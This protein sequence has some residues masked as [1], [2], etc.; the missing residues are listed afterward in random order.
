[1]IAC[2][3]INHI[4]SRIGRKPVILGMVAMNFWGYSLLVC[5]QYLSGWLEASVL[6]VSLLLHMFGGMLAMTFIVNV[7]TVDISGAEDR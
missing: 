5:S 4:S 2:G 1:M 6:V 3:V 7:Y